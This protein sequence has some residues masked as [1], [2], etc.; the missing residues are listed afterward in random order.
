MTG[1]VPSTSESGSWVTI[2]TSPRMPWARAIPPISSR[3]SPFTGGSGLFEDLDQRALARPGS[4]CLDDRADGARGLAAA[5][6]HLAEIGLGDLELVDVSGA[7]LDQLA[8]N[9]VG[10][11]DE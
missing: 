2:T 6:D 5:A 11:V 9:F 10:F 3:G 8:P 1:S 7:F 4:D